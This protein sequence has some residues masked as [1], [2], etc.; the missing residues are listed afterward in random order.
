MLQHISDIVTI[1]F[2]GA[3][4][5]SSI[6]ILQAQF[7]SG[8]TTA[9]LGLPT[10]VAQASVTAGC[11]LIFVTQ[12]IILLNSLLLKKKEGDVA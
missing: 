6:K 3:V 4:G 1:I 2:A 7:Q 5:F 12:V 8:A 11:I 10:W 9:G